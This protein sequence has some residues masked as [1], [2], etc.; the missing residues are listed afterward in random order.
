MVDPG[1][2]VQQLNRAGVE[3]VIIGGVAAT[4]HGCPEQTLDLDIIYA[5]TPAN[6]SR[7][8]TALEAIGA[9][10]D[11]PLN[12][13]ILQHQTV[14]S[15]NTKHGDLDVFT[16]IL[17]LDDYASAAAAADIV[18]LEDAPVKVLNLPVLIATKE[19]AADPNPR[20]RATLDFLKEL[21]RRAGNS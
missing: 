3:Y 13:E 4:L 21:R 8:L 16:R 6:R 12:D 17:G 18:T 9:E 1:A 19:A 11:R 14:F 7:L 10:W 2:I 15:L 20:K 5:P